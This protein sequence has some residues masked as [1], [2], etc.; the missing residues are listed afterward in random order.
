MIIVMTTF[1]IGDD[2]HIKIKQKLNFQMFEHQC[3]LQSNSA[4]LVCKNAIICFEL[5]KLTY[6]SSYSVGIL[7]KYFQIFK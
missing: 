1:T 6:N 5:T 7:Q 4:A 3:Q 2:M